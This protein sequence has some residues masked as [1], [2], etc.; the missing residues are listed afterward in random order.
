MTSFISVITL[1]QFALSFFISSVGT[2]LEPIAREIANSSI[3]IA[4][5]AIVEYQSSITTPSDSTIAIPTQ[6]VPIITV[7]QPIQTQGQ[8]NTSMTTIEII[9]PIGG[10]GLGRTY[11][12]SPEIVDELNY[13][14]IGAIIRNEDGV[15][16]KDAT[17]VVEATDASQNKELVGTGDLTPIYP[18]GKKTFVSYYPF[19]YEFKTSGD[20][21]ITFTTNGV[22]EEV[23]VTVN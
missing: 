6:Y 1:L 10:K 9:S 13:I 19:H 3:E 4:Q 8:Q 21:T 7:T 5:D 11:Q 14:E 2:P 18:N 22:S 20:H 15:V 23:T 17:V 12:A 16:V